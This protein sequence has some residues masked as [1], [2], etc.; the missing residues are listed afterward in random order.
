[1]RASRWRRAAS[2]SA[3]STTSAYRVA[4][5]WWMVV[6]ASRK[7]L[8]ILSWSGW[9]PWAMA[10]R[11]A[12]SG[13]AVAWVGS[14]TVGTRWGP[15]TSGV[16]VQPGWPRVMG[17]ALQLAVRWLGQTTRSMT[18]SVSEQFDQRFVLL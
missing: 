9:S 6:R 4:W 2:G 15:S 10:E 18:G 3:A 12:S 8:R 1:M 17:V 5:S 7:A 11:T 13:L 16:R 14:V